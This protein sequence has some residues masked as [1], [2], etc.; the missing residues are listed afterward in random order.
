MDSERTM[1]IELAANFHFA[2]KFRS[3]NCLKVPKDTRQLSSM[4]DTKLIMSGTSAC[5]SSS[6]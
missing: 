2:L 1:N 4:V 5:I 6:D 3:Y